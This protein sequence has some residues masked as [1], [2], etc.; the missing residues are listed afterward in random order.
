MGKKDTERR[1][2]TRASAFTFSTPKFLEKQHIL[3]KKFTA[4]SKK[5]KKKG[6][7]GPENKNFFDFAVKISSK[8]W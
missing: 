5:S 6:K 2:Y 1:V 7:K 4:K 8:T 3:K